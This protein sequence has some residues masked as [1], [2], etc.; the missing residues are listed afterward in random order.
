MINKTELDLAAVLW[1]FY[2][3]VI[4]R[5]SVATVVAM[6]GMSSQ[7]CSAALP[8]GIEGFLLIWLQVVGLQKITGMP[9][10]NLSQLNRLSFIL[11]CAAGIKHS[12]NPG[13]KPRLPG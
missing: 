8:D 9:A 7:G 2:S 3:S 6:I 1:V 13:E 12:L 10:E 11:H 4:C 5:A